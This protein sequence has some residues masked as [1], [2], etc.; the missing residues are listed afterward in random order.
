MAGSG[1]LG[2]DFI[3]T[4]RDYMNNLGM[5][6]TM[7]HWAFMFAIMMMIIGCAILLLVVL[8]DKTLIK[9][10]T[11]VT[12]LLCFIVFATFL[13]SGLLSVWAVVI[14][15]FAVVGLIIAFGGKVL[16]TGRA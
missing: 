2:G 7:G 3:S 1:T 15:V 16:N 5:D 12:A 10:I 8:K 13:F 6:N 14:L 9:P 4:L 11:W